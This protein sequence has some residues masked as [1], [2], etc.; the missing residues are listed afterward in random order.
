MFVKPTEGRAVP[1]PQRGDILP[2]DG[3]EVEPN[4]YWQRRVNE[5]DVV[6][7]DPPTEKPAS[8]KKK[9]S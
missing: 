5:G 8:G 2:A 9:E 7:A 1:D 4:Q 3:R 6:E